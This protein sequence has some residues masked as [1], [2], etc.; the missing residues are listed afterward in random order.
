LR[1]REVHTTPDIGI[2][3]SDFIFRKQIT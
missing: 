2:I 1:F 3:N